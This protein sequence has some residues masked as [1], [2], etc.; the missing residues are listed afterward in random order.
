MVQPESLHRRYHLPTQFLVT[1]QK[2]WTVYGWIILGREHKETRMIEIKLAPDEQTNTSY[3]SKDRRVSLYISV[4]FI[5][6][7]FLNLSISVTI[8]LPLI[9][10]LTHSPYPF[11]HNN[12]DKKMTCALVSN[13]LTN[14]SPLLFLLLSIL[15]PSVFPFS[16]SSTCLRNVSEQ[17]K[18]TKAWWEEEEEEEEEKEKRGG[19]EKVAWGKG[20]AERK[21]GEWREGMSGERK[22]EGCRARLS[23]PECWAVLC[24]HVLTCSITHI[25]ELFIEPPLNSTHTRWVRPSLRYTAWLPVWFSRLWCISCCVM[26][27]C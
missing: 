18:R 11:L 20:E 25:S 1:E 6:S 19:V 26:V 13:F 21:K 17:H 5:L 14:F 9:S 12:G 3:A 16:L 2:K 7:L 15:F 27:I 24:H 23:G 10:V 22:V 4:A 8:C